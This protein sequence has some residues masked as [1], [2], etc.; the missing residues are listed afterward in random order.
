LVFLWLSGKAGEGRASLE[1][2][3]LSRYLLG[4]TCASRGQVKTGYKIIITEQNLGIETKSECFGFAG[5][6][7]RI[8]SLL[9]AGYQMMFAVIAPAL[10]TGAFAERVLFA[11]YLIFIV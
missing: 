1:I 5:I 7:T 11:P 4:L 8:P 10:I 2:L 6:G 3:G 9:F